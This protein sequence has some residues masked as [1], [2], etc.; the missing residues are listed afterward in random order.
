MRNT[1]VTP[2]LVDMLLL[3]YC[4]CCVVVVLLLCCCYVVVM[5]LCCCFYV[6]LVDTYFAAINISSFYFYLKHDE[7]I[8]KTKHDCKCFGI[9]D[10]TP[11]PCPNTMVLIIR[12]RHLLAIV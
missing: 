11:L 1:I 6:V 3:F 10:K 12:Q 5:L 9:N 2:C 8:K 4:C 7:G